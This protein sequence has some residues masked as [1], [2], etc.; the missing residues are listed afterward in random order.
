[1]YWLHG[2]GHASVILYVLQNK[3]KYAELISQA[4]AAEETGDIQTAVQCYIEALDE[5]SRHEHADFT[6]RFLFLVK[7]AELYSSMHDM[8][9]SVDY[10]IR[11]LHLFEK[12]FGKD[13]S[14]NYTE[15]N[16][17]AVLFEKHGMIEEAH[18]LYL[19]SLAGRLET[20]G[21]KHPD[22]LM[23]MQELANIRVHMDDLPRA[24]PLLEKA[25]IGYENSDERDL[26]MTFLTLMNLATVYQNLGMT[27]HSRTLL[28]Q[29]IPRMR[30]QL[31]LENEMT[32]MVIHNFLCFND[33][34]PIPSDVR[35]VMDE[36]EKKPFKNGTM[37]LE[38]L[39]ED[40]H[41]K[42]QY[43]RAASVMTSLAHL[44]GQESVAESLAWL[45][46]AGSCY[47]IVDKLDEA[48][49]TYN[50]M[51]R[52]ARSPGVPDSAVS[53]VTQHLGN[54]HA[55]RQSLETERLAW[56]LDEPQSCSCGEPTTRRC[57][58]TPCHA[59]PCHI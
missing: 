48:E 29:A 9:A 7:V 30:E 54:L 44:G 22:T 5:M 14:N 33:S 1:M 35:D 51:L 40:Y 39:A 4:A 38:W 53:R 57:S 13:S 55:R 25:Y 31:G 58:G 8:D 59:M 43:Q 34:A 19:R 18:G 21:D 41:A 16:N 42:A 12:L 27:D 50:L 2:D 3:I 17:L 52:A 36:I 24:R 37:V 28:Q 11:A 6:G 49:H 46:R 15:I 45:E 32:I 47:M 10:H 56:R 23:T 20:Q 26:R